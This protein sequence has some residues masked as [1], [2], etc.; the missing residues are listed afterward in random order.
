VTAYSSLVRGSENPEFKFGDSANI[1]KDEVLI[2]IA[3]AHKKTV[4]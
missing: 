1:F 4:A 2:G 3:N